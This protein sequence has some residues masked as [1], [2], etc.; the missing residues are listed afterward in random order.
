VG[1]VRAC[2]TPPK[3]TCVRSSIPRTTITALSLCTPFSAPLFSLCPSSARTIELFSFSGSCH[4]V[5]CCTHHAAM[6]QQSMA[7]QPAAR[8]HG[9]FGSKHCDH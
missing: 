1:S 2:V 5:G 8:M 6:Q 9:P 3:W 4:V 7:C